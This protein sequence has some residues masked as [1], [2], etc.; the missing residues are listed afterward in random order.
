MNIIYP[1]NVF[2][3][4]LKSIILYDSFLTS[5][6]FR[7][8]IIGG[9]TNITGI[10]GAGKT[11]FLNLIPIF[12][13]ATPNSLME[14]AANKKNFVDYYLPSNRSMVIYEYLSHSGTKCVVLYRNNNQ[15]RH[16]YRFV[17]GSAED[18]L[19]TDD[20]L[21]IL[22]ISQNVKDVFNN[23]YKTGNDISRQID[24]ISDYIYILTAD[25]MRLN[26]DRN[27]RD[28]CNIYSLSGTKQQLK[29]LS[30]LTQVTINQNNVVSNF[31]TM[32]IEAYLDN[33]RIKR[34]PTSTAD[35][36]ATINDVKAL[37]SLQT[38]K[39]E[40]INGIQLKD[41]V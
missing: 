12:F 5:K 6:L 23:I 11:S 19:L 8:D 30:N 22:G 9:H 16:N 38:E 13:G 36:L 33:E 32:L 24:N 25:K 31:K 27:L 3:K 40:I 7:V 37:Q 14:K 15:G 21:E 2:F 34:K 39:Q 1:E 28:L 26:G 4:G 17:D 10:N 29:F 35:W 20:C 18:T 41:A